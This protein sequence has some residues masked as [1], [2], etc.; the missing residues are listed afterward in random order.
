ME[1]MDCY[2]NPQLVSRFSTPPLLHHP[3]S[4]FMPS[5]SGLSLLHSIPSNSVPSRM[6]SYTHM[7]GR[8]FGE[9]NVLHSVSSVANCEACSRP[10]VVGL[11]T[12]YLSFS[13]SVNSWV[14]TYPS[15]RKQSSRGYALYTGGGK[16]D[17]VKAGLPTLRIFP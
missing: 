2:P 13:I 17:S 16:I 8:L 1:F 3:Q 9:S 4:L 10:Y 15:C 11:G 14:S 7:L 5:F 12:P 6:R